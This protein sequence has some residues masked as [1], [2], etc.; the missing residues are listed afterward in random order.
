[1]LLKVALRIFPD[2]GVGQTNYVIKTYVKTSIQCSI[3]FIVG[4][5]WYQKIVQIYLDGEYLPVEVL[6][7]IGV[8]CLNKLLQSKFQNDISNEMLYSVVI[9]IIGL[10]NEY[11]YFQELQDAIVWLVMEA[12]S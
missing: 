7:L 8:L 6:I 12:Y 2:I 10:L 11:M 1:M 3:F 9:L 4:F 5:I